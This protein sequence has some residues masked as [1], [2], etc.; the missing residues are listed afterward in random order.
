[1]FKY[2][3]SKKKNLAEYNENRMSPFDVFALEELV[4]SFGKNDLTCLEIDPGLVQVLLRLL[5]NSPKS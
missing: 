2:L 5:V 3:F 1:M 4:S